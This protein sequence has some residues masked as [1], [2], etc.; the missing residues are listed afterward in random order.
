M[1]KGVYAG[2]NKVKEVYLGANRIW[3][4]TVE[5]GYIRFLENSVWTVP[6]GVKTIDIFLVGG[7]GGGASGKAETGNAYAVGGGGGGGGYARSLGDYRYTMGGDGGSG[8]VIVRWKE[9]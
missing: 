9:Q 8:I 4:G 5:A 2:S 6:E 3:K 1:Y 7:G